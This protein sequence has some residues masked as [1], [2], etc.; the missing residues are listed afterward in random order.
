MN[1]LFRLPALFSKYEIQLRQDVEKL[2]ADDDDNDL[3]IRKWRSGNHRHRISTDEI[4]RIC[5]EV[6]YCLQ[7]AVRSNLTVFNLHSENDLSQ[8]IF[9]IINKCKSIETISF[10]R[11]LNQ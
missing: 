1:D 5:D 7:P 10:F 8:A 2:L 3:D 6:M 11:V 4:T 9:R